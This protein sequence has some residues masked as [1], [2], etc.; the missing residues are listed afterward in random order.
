[1][2][3]VMAR[4]MGTMLLQV[5]KRKGW[6]GQTRRLEF[7]ERSVV[8][9]GDPP[10]GKRHGT[11]DVVLALGHRDGRVISP[12]LLLGDYRRCD[13]EHASR[14]QMRCNRFSLLCAP[15]GRSSQPPCHF[16]TFCLRVQLESYPLP[17]VVDRNF[18]Q[19]PPKY[20]RQY[21]K[22]LAA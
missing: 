17:F 14:R 3:L 13:L 8:G 10:R 5:G 15:F 11:G 22:L 20:Q 1:M 6:K 19:R 2:R 18:V 7:I 9:K 4:G 12:L 16:A 21:C